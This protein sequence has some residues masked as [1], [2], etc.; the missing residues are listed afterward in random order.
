MKKEILKFT[1][2]VALDKILSID[3]NILTTLLAIPAIAASTYVLSDYVKKATSNE[4]STIDKE[5]EIKE[6]ENKIEDINA[7]KE[8]LNK[9]K[10]Q[11]KVLKSRKE[12]IHDLFDTEF[13][14]EHKDD[15]V[16]KLLY[17]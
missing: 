12:L 2:I 14:I 7:Q 11:I 17:K 6:I 13:Y 5:K 3:P 15:S 4:T 1:N 10:E 16:K 8:E 9:E